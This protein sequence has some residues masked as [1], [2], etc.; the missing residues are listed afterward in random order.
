MA[1]TVYRAQV[2]IDMDTALPEDVVTNT[3]HFLGQS[4]SAESVDAAAIAVLLEAFYTALDGVIFP[5][6][7]GTTGVIKV[8]DLEDPEPRVPL[9]VEPM[10]VVASVTDGLPAEC[11][12][13]LSYNAGQVSGGIAARRRGR[14]FLGPCNVTMASS[15]G[16][17]VLV[18]ATKITSINTEAESL[19]NNSALAEVPW[20]VYSGVTAV[21]PGDTDAAFIVTGG[22]VDNAFDTIRSRGPAATARTVWN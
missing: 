4:A 7:V 17:R 16:G 21:T 6:E 2:A 18:E 1:N 11:A 22:Y 12:V 10:A 3:F 20:C 15:V 5:K 8:Y 19:M 14:I 13:A 9:L